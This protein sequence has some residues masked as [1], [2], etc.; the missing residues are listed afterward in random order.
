MNDPRPAIREAIPSLVLFD[1]DGT[2]L[3]SAP[4]LLAAINDL[5]AEEGRAPI[6]LDGFRRVVS[7]G[8]L[9]MLAHAFPELD[10]PGWAARLAPFLDRYALATTRSSRPFEGVEAVLERIE[11]AGSRWGVVTNKPGRLADRVLDGMRWHSRCSVLVSGDTLAVKKP[12][13]A[14]LLFACDRLGVAVADSVYVGD[15]ERDIQAARAAGMRSVVALWGYRADLDD[16]HGWG[17]DVV[18]GHPGNLL[19]PGILMPA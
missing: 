18:A 10:E 4:D 1:L 19:D 7:R 14:P 13:P 9:A 15:D 8:G 3:D 11:S 16:P 17:G 12:D 2:L 6:P 5:L